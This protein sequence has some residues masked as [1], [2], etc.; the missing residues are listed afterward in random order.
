MNDS[1][2]PDFV[3]QYCGHGGLS[4][5]VLIS[6]GLLGPTG[7]QG[8]DRPGDIHRELASVGKLSVE[9]AGNSNQ[10]RRIEASAISARVMKFVAFR[11]RSDVLFVRPAVEHNS[12]ALNSS[13]AVSISQASVPLPAL[14]IAVDRV[15]T[16]VR[17]IAF[18][19]AGSMICDESRTPPGP[20]YSNRLPT[21]AGAQSG[22]RRR[23]DF[24]SVGARSASSGLAVDWGSA[25]DTV[26]GTIDA[27]V[28]LL[29]DVPCR[30][31]FAHRSGFLCFLNNSTKSG[32]RHAN[33]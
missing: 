3:Q 19:C 17:G 6:D 24:A 4:N 31:V 26:I 22:G 21:T 13:R 2:F 7:V 18:T 27:H 12:L 16:R 8:A 30:R 25:I 15:K 5:P 29:T 20:A 23:L 28:S 11:D 33:R 9:D 1:F 32:G 14:G 10:M